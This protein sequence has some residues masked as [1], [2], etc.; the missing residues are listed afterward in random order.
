MGVH[1]LAGKHPAASVAAKNGSPKPNSAERRQRAWE[2]VVFVCNLHALLSSTRGL[3]LSAR[4]RKLLTRCG[5]TKW[6]IRLGKGCHK[7]AKVLP[8]DGKATEATQPVRASPFQLWTK[9]LLDSQ[10]LSGKPGLD[11]PGNA[12]ASIKAACFVSRP[13]EDAQETGRWAEI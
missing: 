11:E 4:R 13:P 8:Q 12:R 6:R 2:T 7:K 3:R 1:R 9:Y 5:L 10:R